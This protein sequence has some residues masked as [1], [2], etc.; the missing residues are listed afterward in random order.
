MQRYLDWHGKYLQKQ[1]AEMTARY[2][3]S[4]GHHC[5]L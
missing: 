1:R 4:R 3:Q 2:E 5:C